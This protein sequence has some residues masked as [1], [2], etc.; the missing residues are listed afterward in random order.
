MQQLK[1]YQ[2][3][4]LPILK[5]HLVKYAAIFGSVAKGHSNADSDLDI[6]IEP[7]KNFTLL[8][9]LKLEEEISTLLNAKLTLL[10]TAH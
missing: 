6:L 7:S 3:L 4:I 5:R 10:S 8:N 1:R 2:E 9:M